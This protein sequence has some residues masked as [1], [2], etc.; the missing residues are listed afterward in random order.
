[1]TLLGNNTELFNLFFYVIIE[2]A[3][4]AYAIAAGNPGGVRA[5]SGRRDRGR[6]LGTS[7]C[8]VL[9]WCATE[10]RRSQLRRRRSPT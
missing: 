7:A 1:M 5:T 8:R 10:L 4:L 3:T 2:D 6:A 9:R